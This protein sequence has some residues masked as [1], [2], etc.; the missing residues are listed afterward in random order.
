[1][2]NSEFTIPQFSPLAKCLLVESSFKSRNE[3]IK[4]IK[5]TDI[6][7]D[8]ISPKSLEDGVSAISKETFDACVIGPSIKPET[9]KIYIDE[10]LKNTFSEDCAIVVLYKEEADTEN[11][12]RAHSICKF[13][14]SKLL[15]FEAIVRAILLSNKG[16]VWPGI[17]LSE[18]GK[19]EIK[20]ED[21][22]TV[23]SSSSSKPYEGLKSDFKI[24]ANQNS[25]EE[26][27]QGLQ[28]TPK[29]KL[30][31]ILSSILQIDSSDPFH[32]FFKS[33]ILEWKDELEFS[34]PKEAALNLRWK[35]LN[36][37]EKNPTSH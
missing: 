28:K 35:L 29:S 8:I 13:P 3:I 32:K 33:A 23:I 30:E 19:V 26:F 12:L 22:W 4:S 27:Y 15:L 1:M 24:E 21:N 36:F 14:S 10:L 2:S 17:R 5:S 7:Q 31:K 9:I 16:S 11:F 18:D 25:I 20:L 37:C 6:F 34:T